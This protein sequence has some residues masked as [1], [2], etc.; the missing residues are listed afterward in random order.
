[1]FDFFISHAS[2]DKE[3]IVNNLYSELSTLGYNVWYDKNQIQ[4]GDNINAE[5]E[6]GLKNSFC[7]ILIITKNF[8][9]SKWVYFEFG[10]YSSYQK[11]KIIPIIYDIDTKEYLQILQILGNIKCINASEKV[12]KDIV[13]DLKNALICIKTNNPHLSAKDELLQ[14]GK[15]LKTYEDISSNKI[16]L[17]LDEYFDIMDNHKDYTV[18]SAQKVVSNL[19]CDILKHTNICVS[20]ISNDY[21]NHLDAIKSNF[22]KNIF[23]Y[24][25]FIYTADIH[26]SSDDEIL[27]LNKALTAIF[28]WY[29]G[30]K[31]PVA[32]KK[33]NF[34]IIPPGEMD[35]DSFKETDDI[36]YLV[37][38]ED[39]IASIDTALEW[40]EY[41]NYTYIAIRDTSTNKI[42]GYFTLLPVTEDTYNKI[43]S[44]DFMDKDF[45]KDAI[46]QYETPGIY[47]IYV[48][49]VAIHPNYQNSNAFL[50]LYNAAID[51][52][53]ELAQERD[54]YIDKL[55]AEAS[56]KQGEKLCKLLKM[57]KYC[58]TTTNTD[59]YTLTLI[60]PEF[61][62]FGSKGKVF[63]NLCRQKYE[64]YREY[65]ENYIK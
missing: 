22:S 3:T 32:L 17:L 13:F 4:Y 54:I 36:D 38:R 44:G 45:T 56:T 47:S 61:K 23:E 52:F 63:M 24:I 39:L 53:L 26:V 33:F 11:A 20:P 31:Y 58:S 21:G 41:N 60:P 2:A 7:L 62:L 46:L 14:I 42:A 49:S 35:R 6:N 57:I 65:F 9:N 59:V 28:R 43:L 16:S 1:M 48:A 34:Y 18:F 15:Q 30:I 50:E 27:L 25:N 8:F 12:L 29:L 64:E 40:Y 37:L 19:V 5:I 55:I 10:K 51:M